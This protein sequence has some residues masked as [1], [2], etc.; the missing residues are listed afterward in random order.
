MSD[1]GGSGPQAGWYPDPEVPGGQRY[2]DG[3]QWG[4]QRPPEG[5]GWQQPPP[6]PTPTPSWQQST[7]AWQ[8][9][10]AQGGGYTPV[11]DVDPWLWQSIVATVLCCLPFGIVGIVKSSQARSAMDM[12]N[13][14]VAKQRADEARTWTLVSVGA[15]LLAWVL[16]FG[17][18]VSFA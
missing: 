8:S 10:P 15:G 17:F 9:S 12:G 2:W 16:W 7:P 3:A 4:E 18:V 13:G 1:Q 14:V 6:A 11:N 5:G